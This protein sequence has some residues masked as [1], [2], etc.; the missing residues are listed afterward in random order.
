MMIRPPPPPPNPAMLGNLAKEAG[1]PQVVMMED[2]EYYRV[3]MV[4]TQQQFVVEKDR[5]KAGAQKRKE[6]CKALIDCHACGHR[7]HYAK[8][9]GQPKKRE[10]GGQF[11]ASLCKPKCP[12]NG[13]QRFG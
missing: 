5:L 2:G 9:C 7:G 12:F 6:Q 3:Y 4:L 13:T 11:G 1:K 10:G 8:Y